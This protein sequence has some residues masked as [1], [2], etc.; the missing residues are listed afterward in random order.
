MVIKRSRELFELV[1]TLQNTLMSFA[2]GGEIDA[3]EYKQIRE[4]LVGNPDIQELLPS[5]IRVNRDLRQMWPHFKRV[6][7]TY[8]GRREYLWK[9]FA[10]LLDA[11]QPGKGAPGD[12]RV[13]AVLTV[14]S[15]ASVHS[16]WQTA[17]E[18][19]TSDPDGAITSARTLL[20]TVCKHI[21]DDLKI[22]YDVSAGDGRVARP[23]SFAP[24]DPSM[25]LSRTRLFPRWVRISK[26][27]PPACGQYPHGEE[28]SARATV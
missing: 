9:E 5:F 24:T 3:N 8:Q 4:V 18:R 22:E 23:F 20:E 10:P 27:E 19:R 13:E 15:S 17:L 7:P 25:R 28:E 26:R 1:E 16:A 2:T 14:L 6:S 11:L 21:L 12:E